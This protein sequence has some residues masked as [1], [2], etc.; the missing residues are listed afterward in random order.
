VPSRPRNQ[1]SA[2]SDCVS[3]ANSRVV[4][5]LLR[6]YRAMPGLITDIDESDS[7]RPLWPWIRLEATHLR[8]AFTS[9]P[10]VMNR[11]RHSNRVQRVTDRRV[12]DLEF[13]PPTW[14]CELQ[15][16]DLPLPEEA[17]DP[18]LLD[19]LADALRRDVPCFRPLFAAVERRIERMVSKHSLPSDK[20]IELLTKLLHLSCAERAVLSLC[21]AIEASS[22]GS[23]LFSQFSRQT[24]QIQALQRGTRQASEHDV[25]AAISHQSQLVRSG[26]LYREQTNHSQHRDLE[27]IL[28]L[29]RQGAALLGAAVQSLEDMA[30]A[31]LKPLAQ[32]RAT[33]P[34]TWPHLSERGKLLE[35]LLKNA[36]KSG[37]RGINLLFYGAPGTGKT[38]FASQL[39]LNIG[40]Q[41]YSV[42]DRSEHEASANRHERLAS[43]HLS[44]LFAPAKRSVMVLDEAEDI[45]QDDYNNPLAKVFGAREGSKSWMNS[46]LEDNAQPVIWISNQ[47]SHIDPAYLRRFTYCLDFPTTPRVVRRVQAQRYLEPVGC[48]ADVIDSIASH[49]HVSPAL[50]ASAAR[51]VVMAGAKGAG[52]D[53]AAKHVLIDTLKA[54]GKELASAPPACTT[55]F[56]SAYLNVKGNVT[57]EAIIGG[58]QRLGKGTLL[59]SGPPGTG[60]TQLAAEIA[61]RLGRELV[62]RTAADINTMWFGESER[63]VAR[64]FSQCDPA[65]EILFLD[66]ADTLLTSR[67]AD[68][69]RVNIAVAAEFLR[70]V[71]TFEGV[72]VCAT[73]HSARLDAALMRRFAFR[74]EF[75]P[76]TM[77]QRHRIL[78]ELALQWREESS[79][80]PPSLDPQV[81]ARLVRLDQLTPGDYANVAKRAR[82]LGLVLDAAQWV[83]E[84][85]AEH[86]AKPQVRRT[87]IGFL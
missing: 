73:N 30:R 77:V 29:S 10:A 40:V 64:M 75:D 62:Y 31:V 35:A 57:P 76:L 48:T 74:L 70:R 33:V 45:F 2:A 34:L 72:F 24:R 87:P 84:L 79:D 86:D 21:N 37:T 55:R 78:C 3:I 38:E 56:D 27:D 59:L 44:Q 23:S 85:T 19:I 43:M 69:N 41:G 4:L 5:V 66:E 52:A 15:N 50:L 13:D 1:S 63:N 14:F 25:R 20:N 32:S 16:R 26:L 42:E 51:F 67:E 11:K 47:V 8:N 65:S 36:L 39:L 82:S 60:K 12:A 22:V 81:A 71:E 6:I 68:S 58:L 54:M 80:P 83:D 61:Q 53:V 18:K 28:R 46:I 7:V 9:P 17:P 49:E